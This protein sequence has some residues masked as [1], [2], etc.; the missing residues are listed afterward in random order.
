MFVVTTSNQN[1]NNAERGV[2]I[3]TVSA[4]DSDSTSLSFSMTSFPVSP[5][6]FEIDAG[7]TII[8]FLI[9]LINGYRCDPYERTSDI[10][11]DYRLKVLW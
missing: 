3:Y 7:K 1:A 2:T 11:L 4:S 8:T 10:P 6:L 9:K 5:S